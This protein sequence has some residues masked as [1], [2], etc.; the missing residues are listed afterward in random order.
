QFNLSETTFL[1]P[2]DRASARV[3]IFTPHYEM[4]FAGHPTLGTAHV[5]RELGWAGDTLT[6]E[7]A[8][9]VIPVQASGRR[10]TLQA[11]APTWREVPEPPAT[12]ASMLGIDER[13]I[14]ERPLWVDTG[15]EQL[16][17]P[18][19]HEAAVRRAKPVADILSTLTRDGAERMAYV[20]APL[21]TPGR[22]LS[23][24]FFP[25]G[26]AVIEDPATGSATANLGGWYLAMG[27]SL[28]QEFEI[29]QGE[30]A[31]RPS[32][33]FLQVGVDRA[34]RVSGEVIELGR[35]TITL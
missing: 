31:G 5:C 9:G 16:V 15:T 13:E 29:S 22:L 14:G 28:P 26:G 27:R 19:T 7:M 10:W 12:L 6:L 2:S 32:T 33:L 3:R 24:F 30:Y 8:A 20:F 1:L 17:I 21:Q 11:N 4:R 18:V 35:G 25:Q 23:R 34:I